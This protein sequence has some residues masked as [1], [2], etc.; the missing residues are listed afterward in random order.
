MPSPD[1]VSYW[2]AQARERVDAHGILCDTMSKRPHQL[3]RLLAYDWIDQRVLEIGTGNGIVAGLL[4]GAVQGC[5]S[6][7]GTELAPGFIASARRMFDLEVVQADVTELP[8]CAGGY[9]RILALDSLEHVAHADRQRGYRRIA[10]VAAPGCLLF[11]H[12]SRSETR[13]DS[14]FDHPFGL[15]DID[16]LEGHGFVLN[17]YERYACRTP[18]PTLDLAFVVMQREGS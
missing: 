5:W 16:I 2:E 9:T 8:A 17:S 13:H 4:K 1:E 15:Q 10:E 18:G 14:R 12:L 11:I 3:R 6:Y 7:T